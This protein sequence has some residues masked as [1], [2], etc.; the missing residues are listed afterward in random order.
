MPQMQRFAM[1]TKTN[2]IL[3]DGIKRF[4]RTVA[5]LHVPT[6]HFHQMFR[7]GFEALRLQFCS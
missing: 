1:T 2:L 4:V 5:W 6:P 3:E 7:N